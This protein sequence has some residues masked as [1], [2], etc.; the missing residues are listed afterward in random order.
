MAVKGQ[1]RQQ[2]LSRL[3]Q[4]ITAGNSVSQ[5]CS[6]RYE[7]LNDLGVDFA[8]VGHLVQ[9]PEKEFGIPVSVAELIN[10]PTINQLA[11][12]LAD[13]L[14]G[15]QPDELPEAQPPAR[16][17]AARELPTSPSAIIDSVRS[18]EQTFEL[19]VIQYQQKMN[20][21]TNGNGPDKALRNSAG[22][23]G[24]A[25]HH[26]T[27]FSR[28]THGAA[29][30]SAGKWLVAPRANPKAKSPPVL[31]SLC[32]WRH[33]IV[34]SFGHNCSMI[35]WNWWPSRRRDAGPASTK[36]PSMI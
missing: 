2:L 6:T 36:Q 14:S 1:T 12:Y 4:H 31:L 18:M 24:D 16:L 5:K 22:K 11:D 15:A 9:Q 35:P 17:A 10:G 27:L 32:R 26:G 20:P 28:S 7:R 8:D 21:V 33:C 13:M 19:R 25:E 23:N 30:F 3:Q 29:E 34:P